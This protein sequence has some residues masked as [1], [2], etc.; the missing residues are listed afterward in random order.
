MVIYLLRRRFVEF[1]LE[2][3]RVKQ[4]IRDGHDFMVYIY[5]GLHRNT[6]YFLFCSY[7]LRHK[8]SS[9]IYSFMFVLQ[10]TF[11]FLIEVFQSS[12]NLYHI[13]S[14]LQFH[15]K[16]IRLHLSLR[17]CVSVFSYC[18]VERTVSI[19]DSTS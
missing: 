3:S 14:K 6:R 11:K 16:V 13:N 10:D 15:Y 12:Q 9:Y 1:C 7:L 18:H 17:V 19:L 2:F 5:Y 4:T 8:A